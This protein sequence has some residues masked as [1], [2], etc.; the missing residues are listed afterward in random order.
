V[1]T[2]GGGE[3]YATL[4]KEHDHMVVCNTTVGMQDGDPATPIGAS[5]TFHRLNAEHVMPEMLDTLFE[6]S[7]TDE[8]AHAG[9]FSTLTLQV[10]VCC[11][12]LP[13]PIPTRLS[14]P[15]SARA[16]LPPSPCRGTVHQ[17]VRGR[18]S[19]D[20]VRTSSANE[21]A[22]APNPTNPGSPNPGEFE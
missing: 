20:D 5:C 18:D 4:I 21:R 10:R 14:L 13:V 3:K 7:A 1:K 19:A 6:A 8:D 9:G 15:F 2:T 17:E 22:P 11:P 16:V 12:L